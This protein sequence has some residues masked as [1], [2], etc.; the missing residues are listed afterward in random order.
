MGHYAEGE[1]EA[2]PSPS[3]DT[4]LTFRLTSELTQPIFL[5]Q[6]SANAVTVDWGDGSAT[7]TSADTSAAFSHTYA[8]A[9][10]YTVTVA[11]EDG[12][13]W[14]P[15]ATLPDGESSATY[16]L[17]GKLT[18]VKSPAFP[19]LISIVLGKNA[20]LLRSSGLSHCTSITTIII[21]NTITKIA[22]DE[23][24]DCSS[25]ARIELPDT[26]SDL[27]PWAIRSCT[28]LT[29]IVIPEGVTADFYY[30]FQSDT[31]LKNAALPN[32]VTTAEGA[33]YMCSSLEHLILGSGVTRITGIVSECTALKSLTCRAITPPTIGSLNN[34]NIPADCIFYVPAQ[35][36]SA[37]QAASGWSDRAAY[38]QAEVV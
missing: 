19:T 4:I 3:E 15:G 1:S 12:E 13:T 10:D 29:E 25:L 36:V 2:P 11:C 37:Y 32:S 24:N 14:S 5:T 17:L 34:S 9:G 21:P 33:F 38:I 30:T 7:E 16:C 26:L 23:F 28:A 35:S 8:A 6:S 18:G 22:M 31:A 20:R 27:E